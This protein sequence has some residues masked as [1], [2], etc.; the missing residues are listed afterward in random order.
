[1]EIAERRIDEIAIAELRGRV[2]STTADE[3]EARLFSLVQSGCSGLVIDFRQVAYMSSAGFRVLLVA[4]RA[5]QSSRCELALCEIDGEL[6]RLFEMG[7]FD[8]I[9]TVL[10]TRDEC[11][12]HLRARRAAQAGG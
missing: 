6:R 12:A 1:M 2:D 7:G 8:E 10:P 11:V 5:A 9:F 4:A 3:V